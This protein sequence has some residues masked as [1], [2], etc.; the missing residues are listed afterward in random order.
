MFGFLKKK[1]SQEELYLEELEQRRQAETSQT[2]SQGAGFEMT[3]DDVFAIS[4]RGTVVTGKVG[5][6]Q[7]R[8]G[9]R[10]LIRSLNGTVYTAQVGGIEAFRKTLEV[11]KAG[12]TVGLL[13]NGIRKDQIQRGD[14]IRKAL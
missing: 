1:K 12:D 9:D 3:V 10:V 14:V 13:L 11:A 6:G 2:V 5:H 8:K 7:L 4:G